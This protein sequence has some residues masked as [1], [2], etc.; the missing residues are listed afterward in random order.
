MGCWIRNQLVE[1]ALLVAVAIAAVVA[2]ASILPVDAVVLAASFAGACILLAVA[3]GAFARG[4]AKSSVT[5]GICSEFDTRC[6]RCIEA[7]A[8]VDHMGS[9]PSAD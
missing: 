8:A 5:C 9:F 2:D 7:V 1:L 6:K 4:M 3:A